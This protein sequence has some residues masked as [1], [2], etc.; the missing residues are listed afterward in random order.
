MN[1]VKSQKSRYIIEY[2]SH[3]R[4]VYFRNYRPGSI[5]ARFCI[6]EIS[7][8]KKI[9]TNEVSTVGLATTFILT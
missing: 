7:A 8:I 6:S 2:F 9:R 5:L 3:K 4:I 1:L